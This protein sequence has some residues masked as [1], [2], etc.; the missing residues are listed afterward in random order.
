MSPDIATR[1][2]TAGHISGG[3]TS[4]V[5]LSHLLSLPLL[6]LIFYIYR[7]C[8]LLLPPS[9]ARF[10]LYSPFV[11][12]FLYNEGIGLRGCLRSK[13]VAP[14][15][16]SDT[17]G[18]GSIASYVYYDWSQD[19]I[20]VRSFPTEVVKTASE[21]TINEGLK[22]VESSSLKTNPYSFGCQ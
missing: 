4:A 10:P 2:D 7:R 5:G 14:G 11:P 15:R 3:N 13:I 21:P 12:P 6:P 20:H 1:S 19:L 22:M 8:A 18:P 17:R 9:R 16:K